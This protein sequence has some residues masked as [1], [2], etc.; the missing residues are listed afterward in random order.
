MSRISSLP[1]APYART[2]TEAEPPAGTVTSAG[3]TAKASDGTRSRTSVMLASAP[4]WFSIR[5]EAEGGS[6]PVG[7]GRTNSEAGVR[8]RQ[9][10]S[11]LAAR[12]AGP[13]SP[14]TT[15]STGSERRCPDR[16]CSRTSSFARPCTVRAKEPSACTSART[17]A[18]APSMLTAQ[19]CA[20]GSADPGAPTTSTSMEPMS[21]SGA[22][23]MVSVA[24]GSRGSTEGGSGTGLMPQLDR[25]A[26]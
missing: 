22:R 18:L 17:G 25:L 11:G 7:N 20:P 6:E 10:A 4:H 8:D 3:S 12:T 23:V 14:G 19:I 16:T 24:G 13:A 5:I 9:A 26:R 1:G 15:T 21:M 2:V